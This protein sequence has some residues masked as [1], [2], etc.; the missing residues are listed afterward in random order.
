M[1][2]YRKSYKKAIVTTAVVILLCLV[3]LTGATL[4]LFTNDLR[5]GTIGIITTA[6]SVKVDIVNANDG[7]TSLVGK[8]L[9][10]YTSSERKEILFEPGATIR[11]EGFKVKNLGNVPV[12]F[13]VFISKDETVVD[14]SELEQIIGYEKLTYEE[15]SDAFDVWITTDPDDPDKHVEMDEFVGSLKPA[16][17][18]TVNAVTDETYYLVVRMKEDANNDFQGKYYKGIGVTVYAIQ[19]NAQLGE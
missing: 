5:D 17:N 9:S 1:F 10:F 6:G 15:F 12:N 18:E 8:V 3:C 13:R 19:G 14:E 7:E 16:A 2:T 4:A 11:T